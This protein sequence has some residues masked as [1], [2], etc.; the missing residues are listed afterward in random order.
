MAILAFLYYRAD[1]ARFLWNLIVYR[2]LVSLHR[3]KAA[4]SHRR[5]PQTIC[6]SVCVSV[7]PMRCGQT[8]DQIWM[9][10]GMVGRMGPRMR[11][12]AGFGIGLREG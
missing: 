9:R 8:A 7:C 3:A 4:H 6:W 2:E 12:I 1:Y 10:F 5:C 11:Q